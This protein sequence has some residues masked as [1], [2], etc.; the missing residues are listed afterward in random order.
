[1]DVAID[2]RFRGF[3]EIAHGGYVGGLLAAG[4]ASAEVTLR[5]PVPVERALHV[6]RRERGV[7]E[8]L[9]A[10]EVLARLSPA[11]LELPLPAPVLPDEATTAAMR[12]VQRSPGCRHLFPGC[13]GCGNGRAEGDA[14]RLFA[15]PV[16]GR[17][18]VA[19]V[20]IPDTRLAA[21]GEVRP[22]FVW[23]ALDCPTIMAAVFGSP[24]GST[25][26]VVTYRLAV[27]RHAPVRAGVASVI[28]G[29]TIGREPRAL[30]A[31]GA[32]FSAEGRVLAVARHTL[33]FAPWGVP[34]GLDHWR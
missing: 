8:L 29:W 34:V 12:S 33:A 17:D 16:Q 32:I 1:M 25:E 11:Q 15:G 31:G 26:R 27:T 10:D 4:S 3:E 20:W 30:V 21:D 19:T 22:E 7:L 28:V 14:L 24:P 13:F 2:A 6:E 9:E 23:A 5:R 18:L